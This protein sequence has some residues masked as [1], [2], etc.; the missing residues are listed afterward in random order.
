MNIRINDDV[1]P[2]IIT[3]KNNKNMY[4]RIK[5]DLNIYVT[6]PN[7]TSDKTITRFI[8]DNSSSITKMYTSIKEKHLRLDKRFLY[9][10]NAYTICYDSVNDITFGNKM[11]FIP[12]RLNIDN[13]YKKQAKILFK[14]HLDKCYDEF[15]CDIPYPTLKIR[16]MKSKW[17]VCNVLKKEVTLN[18]NL[19]KLDTKYLDYVIIH[20][21]SHL[22]YPNHSSKFWN[23]VS[24]NNIDYKKLRNEMKNIL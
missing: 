2:V 4:L 15:P 6:A 24:S 20:E 19:I 7:R 14:E 21:L 11:V 23:L 22:V 18:L 5:D 1:V 13:W 17:G 8:Q 12:K 16:N 9:L 10:G 3:Y